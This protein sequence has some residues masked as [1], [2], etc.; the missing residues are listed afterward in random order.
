MA[1]NCKKKPITPTVQ[2]TAKIVDAPVSNTIDTP[3]ESSEVDNNT[4]ITKI[5]TRLK[6]IT[7]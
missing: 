7:R 4:L 6:E 3:I 2:A 5:T 1:C